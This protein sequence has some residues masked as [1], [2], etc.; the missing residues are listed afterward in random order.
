MDGIG[1]P[2]QQIEQ[3]YRELYEEDSHYARGHSHCAKDVLA[4]I[5][6]VR[7]LHAR[8]ISGTAGTSGSLSRKASGSRDLTHDN[9]CGRHG[10]VEE[11]A[12]LSD[13]V[14]DQQ[15]EGEVTAA[16]PCEVVYLGIIDPAP[17]SI[18]RPCRVEAVFAEE[19][20]AR[21][22]QHSGPPVTANSA[23]RTVEKHE[24]VR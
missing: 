6:E 4:L 10:D 14:V 2:L 1:P 5:A 24:V 9:G 12:A 17:E 20:A 15:S 7:K 22:W 11:H 8:P 13:A 21:E 18:P 3:D 23:L 16:S 19:A